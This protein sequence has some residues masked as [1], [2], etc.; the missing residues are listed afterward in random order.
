M[1]LFLYI[2]SVITQK[3]SGLFNY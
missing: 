3:K 2:R 1:F